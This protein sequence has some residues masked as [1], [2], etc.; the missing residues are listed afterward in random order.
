MIISP[1]SRGGRNTSKGVQRETPGASGFVIYCRGD[2]DILLI[3]PPV[4][5]LG[6]GTVYLPAGAG[7]GMRFTMAASKGIMSLTILGADSAAI[8][9]PPKALGVGGKHEFLYVAASNS[10]INIMNV[11]GKP[12]PAPLAAGYT[13]VNQVSATLYDTPGALNAL[14]PATASTS[15]QLSMTTAPTAPYTVILTYKPV[16]VEYGS[17]NAGFALVLR[18]STNGR[19]TMMSS[20]PNTGSA[21][22]A[23]AWNFNS[24]TSFSAGAFTIATADPVLGFRLD[25]T[26]TTYTLYHGDDEG[27]SWRGSASFGPTNHSAFLTATG[28]GTVDQIGFGTHSTNNTSCYN[29]LSFG[30]YI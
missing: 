1:G 16:A 11:R 14:Y 27:W 26:S 24:A 5:A 23:S 4:C 28:G 22:S 3:D 25:V 29:I 10:W 15:V 21:R 7:D 9:N 8:I 6:S 30:Y 17:V 19:F 2:V 12:M 18:N 20:Y 13:W